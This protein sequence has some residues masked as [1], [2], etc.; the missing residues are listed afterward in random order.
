MNVW[1]NLISLNSDSPPVLETLLSAGEY[2]HL[3]VGDTSWDADFVSLESAIARDPHPL[4]SPN[5][6]EGYFAQ[7]HLS[8]W[9][10]GF[11]AYRYLMQCADLYDVKVRRFLDLGCC[12]GR[13]LRHF[14]YQSDGIEAIGCDINRK[15]ADWIMRFL[16]GI[17]AMQTHSIPSI[18]LADNSLDMVS[19]FSVFTHIEAFD[20]AWLSE[21]K[22]I[23][24]PG[25]LAWISFHSEKTWDEM[26]DPWPLYKAMLVYPDFAQKHGKKLEHEFT[27]FR[28]LADRSYTSN[29]FI[30]TDYVKRV[31]GA[32]MPILEIRRRFPNYQ[33]IAIFQKG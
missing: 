28:H 13:V 4:P 23:L 32:V 18:P 17:L 10:S 5:N 24:R 3:G 12:S 29:V 1:E 19:A 22:R 7:N 26:R 15:Y 33:D 8:Y 30:E 6:R 27:V 9:V 2:L 31:W 21:I 16:P 11:K 20:V 25:G 14:A